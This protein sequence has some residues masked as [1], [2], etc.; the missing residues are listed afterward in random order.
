MMGPFG[1]C[2]DLLMDL[3]ETANNEIPVVIDHL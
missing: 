3:E 2:C 1:Q